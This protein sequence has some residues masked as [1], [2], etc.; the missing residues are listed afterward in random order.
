MRN[1]IL[2]FVRKIGNWNTSIG[3]YPDVA[4]PFYDASNSSAGV[5]D[6]TSNPPIF[7]T[8]KNQAIGTLIIMA[9]P[10][11]PDNN[12]LICNGQAISRTTYSVLFSIIN[13]AWGAGNGS[14]TFN[15]P[16]A[17]AIGTL[18]SPATLYIRVLQTVLT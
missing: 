16:P 7:L 15:L 3:R 5:G 12:F 18:I 1:E 13:V 8:N 9:T 10:I 17:N 6:G 14:T 11:A 2:K 4:E